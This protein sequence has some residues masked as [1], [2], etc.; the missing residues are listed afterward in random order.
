VTLRDG[1]GLVR[2]ALRGAGSGTKAALLCAA[3]STLGL[4]ALEIG[5]RSVLFTRTPLLGHLRQASLYADYYSD[6]DYWKL[7]Y[8]LGAPCRPPD[9]PDPLLGWAGPF[10]GPDYEHPSAGSL[11]ERRA[12][13]LYGD[14][15]AA[16]AAEVRGCFED[17][18]NAR[19]SFSERHFLLNHGVGG[20][21][22]DQIVLLMEQTV[23]RYRDPFVVFSLLTEDIDRAVLSVRCG[24]KPRF[25][26][27]DGALAPVGEPIDPIPARYFESHPPAIRS[28]LY[29]LLR[30]RLPAPV[31]QAL[32]G[33]AEV[34]RQKR[35]LA[36]ALIA[37]ATQRLRRAGIE[38]VFLVF[39]PAGTVRGEADDW[40][41][42]F[43]LDLLR[44]RE[45]PFLSASAIIRRDAALKNRP[46]SEY[47]LDPADGHPS[48]AQVS[49]VADAIE[50]QV[51][52]GRR[53]H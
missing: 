32:A 1:L 48:A 50:A 53:S 18:L 25:R 10:R 31:R 36:A 22:L 13:L 33:S 29:R 19:R 42:R 14:S 34:D 47:F 23:G 2:S 15:F 26:L 5:L 35:D 6:D 8:A 44:N 21:G 27:V 38:H 51:V 43:L 52:Q 3:V 28:Y 40:R 41:E 46:L 30:G 20:Y 24:Q 49:A 9:R 16:C 7:Q 39:S 45:I 12:V 11:G 17:V 37:R 4:A